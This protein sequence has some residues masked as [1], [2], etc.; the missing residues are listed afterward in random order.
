MDQWQDQYSLPWTNNKTNRA[1]HGPMTRL[2]HLH[3]TNNKTNTAY[4]GPITRPIELT[5]DQWQDQYS[6][7]WTNNKT[8]RSLVHG[9]LYWS[10]YWT[11]ISC[12]GLVIG[13]WSALLVLLLAQCQLYWS[14]YWPSVS[15]TQNIQS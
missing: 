6:L 4:L 13:P 9:Q 12:I 8:N 10:C 1:D 15:E 3:K 2:I 11:K 14:C 5:M 7:P